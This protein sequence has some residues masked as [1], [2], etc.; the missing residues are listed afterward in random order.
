[1]REYKN[2]TEKL[3]EIKKKNEEKKK[4]NNLKENFR[5]VKKEEYHFLSPREMFT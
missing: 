1:L 4:E 2:K 5:I 3:K